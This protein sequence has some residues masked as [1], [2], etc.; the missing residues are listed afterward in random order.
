MKELEMLKQELIKVGVN[1]NILNI[2]KQDTLHINADDHQAVRYDG[3]HFYF[4]T[5]G[6]SRYF[7]TEKFTLEQINEC[8]E[9]IKKF[10]VKTTEEINKEYSEIASAIM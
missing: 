2:Y 3:K 7:Y 10:A 1:S 6:G 9:F 4:L 5:V 8:A